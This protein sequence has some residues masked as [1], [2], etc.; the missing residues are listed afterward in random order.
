M[1]HDEICQQEY[2]FNFKSVKVYFFK[3]MFFSPYCKLPRKMCLPFA[4]E[5]LHR[6]LMSICAV[7]ILDLPCRQAANEYFT[8]SRS[9]RKI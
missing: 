2:V 4:I 3:Y 7:F 9:K 1:R 5:M 8:I 6:G